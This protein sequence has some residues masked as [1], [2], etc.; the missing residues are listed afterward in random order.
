MLA[1]Q[2]KHTG[3]LMTNADPGPR[4]APPPAPATFSNDDLPSSNPPLKVVL[5]VLGCIGIFAL[6]LIFHKS[7]GL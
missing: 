6:V 7:L 2:D 5:A 4:K 1:H 3:N